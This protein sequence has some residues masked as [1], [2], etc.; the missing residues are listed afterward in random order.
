V[1]VSDHGMQAYPTSSNPYIAER[2]GAHDNAEDGIAI[3]W[4]KHIKKGHRLAKSPSIF[5][6]A[7]TVLYLMGLPVDEEMDGGVLFDALEPS[8]VEGRPM[9]KM[10]YEE[11]KQRVE[12]FIKSEHDAELIE[13]LRALGYLK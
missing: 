11:K 1:V 8:F 6:M 13:R 5:D 12:G 9:E 3:F 2:T 4:G 7:P 10:R